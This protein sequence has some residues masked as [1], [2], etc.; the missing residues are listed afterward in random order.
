MHTGHSIRTIPFESPAIACTL[1]ATELADR[2]AE[3]QSLFATALTVARPRARA[4]AAGAVRHPPRRG[5]GA[6]SLLSVSPGAVSSS[7]SPS[8]VTVTRSSWA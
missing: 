2:L 1:D 7:H 5:R 3:F 6:G 8:S 4:P